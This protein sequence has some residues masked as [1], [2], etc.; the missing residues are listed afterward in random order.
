MAFFESASGRKDSTIRVTATD[1]FSSTLLA[2]FL[3]F[4]LLT[5]NFPGIRSTLLPATSFFT[6]DLLDPN[7]SLFSSSLV[8]DRVLYQ[9]QKSWTMPINYLHVLG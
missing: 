1:A 2:V 8:A 7:L 3:S 9:T 6:P 5:G 4:S